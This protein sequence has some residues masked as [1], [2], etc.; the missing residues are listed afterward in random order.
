MNKTMKELESLLDFGSEKEIKILSRLLKSL[1]KFRGISI[2]FLKLQLNEWDGYGISFIT[3]S[4][5]K[6]GCSTSKSVLFINIYTDH[7]SGGKEIRIMG[8]IFFMYRKLWSKVIRNKKDRCEQCDDF[9]E[10]KEFYD[11][12]I[13]YCSEECRDF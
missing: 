13:S 10:T 11:K 1:R 12:D 8:G 5:F 9:C 7:S 2:S 6:G 3:I 4:I